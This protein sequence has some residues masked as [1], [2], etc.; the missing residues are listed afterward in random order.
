MKIKIARQTINQVIHVAEKGRAVHKRL[1]APFGDDGW[2]LI[3]SQ[4]V[5]EYTQEMR[6]AKAEFQSEVVDIQN[7][8]PQI[9][10]DEQTRLGPM[11]NISDYPDQYAVPDHF[12]F[13]HEMRPVPNEGH[14][15]IDIEAETLQEIKDNFVKNEERHLQKAMLDTW[16]KLL[17]PV[18]TMADICGNDKKVFKSVIANLESVVE[19]VP[20]LNLVD[21]KRLTDIVEDIKNN[22]LGVTVGQ[23]R[24]DKKLK[25]DLGIE[26]SKISDIMDNYM[27]GQTT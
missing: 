4:S 27:G 15:I 10:N 11:F 3:P 8:W 18:R 9:L 1:T 19:I 22:L 25:E 20:S 6:D 21:D 2:R 12:F 17:E 13:D 16:M 5:L 24:D 7:R 14:I 26:A 23:I